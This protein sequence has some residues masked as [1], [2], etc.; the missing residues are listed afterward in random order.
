MPPIISPLLIFSRVF[1]FRCIV[2]LEPQ[3]LLPNGDTGIIRTLDVPLYLTKAVG[4]KL[5]CLDREGKTRVMDID[6]TEA[7]AFKMLTQGAKHSFI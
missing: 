1:F 2:S 7:R 3:Y 4:K 6:N 5:F